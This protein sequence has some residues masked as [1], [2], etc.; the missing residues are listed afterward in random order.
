MSGPASLRG[1]HDH[2]HPFLLLVLA[3]STSDAY[4]TAH[5]E[6]SHDFAQNTFKHKYQ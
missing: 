3:C 6:K 4:N 2:P 1:F 5:I